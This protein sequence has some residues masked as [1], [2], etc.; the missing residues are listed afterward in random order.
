MGKEEIFIG[1][2]Y[3]Y[4]KPDMNCSW[5]GRGR[6]V[7]KSKTVHVRV[8]LQYCLEQNTFLVHMNIPSA[9]FWLDQSSSQSLFN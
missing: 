7:V 3:V 4:I 5:G 8:V 6:G 1:K 9:S 2:K